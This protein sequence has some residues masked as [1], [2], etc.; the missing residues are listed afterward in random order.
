MMSKEENPKYLYTPIRENHLRKLKDQSSSFPP[1]S[2]FL[3]NRDAKS[4]FGGQSGLVKYQKQYLIIYLR[5][6]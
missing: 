2:G 4:P 1:V 6:L 5:I 3:G